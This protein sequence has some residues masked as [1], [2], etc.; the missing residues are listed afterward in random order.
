MRGRSGLAGRLAQVLVGGAIIASFA[1]SPGNVRAAEGDDPATPP[2]PVAP[3]NLNLFAN[4][5]FRYQDP[6]FVAC[7]ATSTQVMLN[8]INLADSGGDS[9]LWEVSTSGS[10]R[11]SVLRYAR[12]HDTAATTTRGTDPHGWRNALNYYGWGTA[13]LVAGQR[14]YEDQAY[15]TAALAIKAA[16]RQMILT[17]KP[18]GILGWAGRHAQYITGYYGLSGDPFA[19]WSTGT[20]RNAFTIAGVYLTDPLRADAMIN[21]RV[22]YD[23]FRSTGSLR[24]RF[25]AYRETDSPLDDPYTSGSHPSRNEWYNQFVVIMPVR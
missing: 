22:S 5:A 13:A 18:V 10:T 15:N 1:A 23:E 24:V 4:G 6:N 12:S 7:A 17:K 3:A 14:V 21:H 11:D 16:V 25:Q 19:T 8:L 9:F 20:Y 2:A